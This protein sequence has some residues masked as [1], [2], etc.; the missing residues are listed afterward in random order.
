ME[1]PDSRTRAT[2]PGCPPPAQIAGMLQA[3]TLAP[4]M[5]NTQPWRFRIQ[6]DVQTIEL[7]ADPARMLA[8]SDPHGRAVH[9][10][11]GAALFNL[12]VAVAVAGRQPVVRLLPAPGEP[13]LMATLRFAGPH[14]P[15]E[16]ERDLYAA[17]PARHTNRGPYSGRPVPPGVLAELVQAAQLE[18]ASL[19]V[20]GHLEAQRLLRLAADAETGLLG[21]PGYRAELARWAGGE[22]GDDG[23]PGSAVGP[24][25]PRGST[26]V[27]DFLGGPVAGY[28]WFEESPQ[29]AVLST[30]TSTRAD[31]LRAGQALQRV[32]LTATCHGIAACPLTHP[33]ETV[34]AWLVR[35]PGSGS[36]SPQLILRI[37]Y[38]L[39]AP[40]TPRRPVSDVLEEPPPGK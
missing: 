13:S 2:G 28:A 17:I 21:D 40:A 12:R 39:P 3:A 19:H 29:L 1:Q 30:T 24:R 26:P 31:W 33:L 7:Y 32:L 27:R 22:R 5:H 9:I 37:G 10:G 34:D 18:G 20:P 15:D 16:A 35:D 14:R 23:I 38:G 36:G 4:S 6:R 25:D 8:R 11:C